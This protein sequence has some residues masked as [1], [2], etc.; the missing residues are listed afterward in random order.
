VLALGAKHGWHPVYLERPMSRALA[1]KYATIEAEAKR[2]DVNPRT[3]RRM[4]SR[5]QLTGYRL[6]DR[7]IRVDPVEVDALMQPIS[8]VQRS[9]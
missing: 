8:T 9:A 2:L 5:G 3:I 1:R 7:L 4:I 6:G